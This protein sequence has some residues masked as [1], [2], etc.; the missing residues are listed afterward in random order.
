MTVRATVTV[1]GHNYAE[2]RVAAAEVA[3]SLYGEG[4]WALHDLVITPCLVEHGSSVP[5]LW[6]AEADLRLGVRVG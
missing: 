5:V 2:L 1:N 6:E 4:N 3:N